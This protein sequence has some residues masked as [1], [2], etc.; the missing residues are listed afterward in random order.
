MRMAQAGG[1][2]SF[3]W[4]R[5]NGEVAPI[6]DPSRARSGSR[7]WTP[8]LPF[9]ALRRRTDPGERFR[10]VGA[11]TANAT[12]NTGNRSLDGPRI[13]ASQDYCLERKDNRLLESYHARREA[14][15]AL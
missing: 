2:R 15:A 14:S 11:K 10:W 9:L 1:E 12:P 5:P 8:K 13:V 7:G 6:P 4:P 3:T